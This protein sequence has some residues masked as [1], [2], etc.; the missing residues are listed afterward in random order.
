MRKLSTVCLATV[1]AVI[2]IAA[3]TIAQGAPTGGSG[4]LD[5]CNKGTRRCVCKGTWEGAE[6]QKVKERCDLS[7]GWNCTIEPPHE[8][9]CSMALK[10][11]PRN[12]I[13]PSSG[14]PSK[15]KKE[16]P[17]PPPPARPF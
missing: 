10:S 6:C 14:A 1:A 5:P 13:R 15:P 4:Y 12:W 9:S 2:I 11:S 7:K 8:C 3:N 17:P 16:L